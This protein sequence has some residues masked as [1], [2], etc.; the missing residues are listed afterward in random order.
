M[1]REILDQRWG[2]DLKTEVFVIRKAKE[3][4][5]RTEGRAGAKAQGQEK[6]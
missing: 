5:V 4:V 1:G 3:R 6:M 2:L